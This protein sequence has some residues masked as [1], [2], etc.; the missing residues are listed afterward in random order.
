[1]IFIIGGKG[2]VGSGIAR[3]CE[4]HGIDYQVITR[5]NYHEFVGKS[6]DILINANG[7]SKKFLAKNEPKKEF[8]LSVNSVRD[9]LED[10]KY[11]KYVFFST[12]DVY[13]D[14]EHPEHNSED[15]VI[16]I[17]N[18]SPY[19]FHKYLA[20]QCVRHVAKD[21]LIL[22]FG[23]FVGPNLKK[24]AIFDILNG[25]PLWL[26][27]KS[28]LQFLH[29]DDSARI[30]FDLINA[31]LSREIFNVCGDGLVELQEV[32]QR[33]GKHVPVQDNSPEVCY[34]VNIDK[35]KK[36]T[37]VPETRKTVFEFVDDHC[38]G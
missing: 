12:C 31:G 28:R 37:H 21:W 25:G 7:N 34:H 4:K 27:P 19:G 17:A 38:K 13:N 1:M 32:I 24:N 35:L 23:G 8:L 15:A 11:N 18:Q 29:T 9:S 3:H 10:F 2:F 36:I 26:D 20:E 30:V 5:E 14:C 6:C 16:D 22:R 33:T